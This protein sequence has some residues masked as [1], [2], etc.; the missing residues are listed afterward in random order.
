MEEFQREAQIR[1][2][3]TL[4]FCGM[5]SFA[6]CIHWNDQDEIEL[7]LAAKEREVDESEQN[8]KNYE[9]TLIVRYDDMP[10]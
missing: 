5:S 4:K 9:Q 10:L 2:V 7:E 1:Q 6:N 3:Q 8:I